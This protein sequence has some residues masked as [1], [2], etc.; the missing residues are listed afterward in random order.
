MAVGKFNK[1]FICLGHGFYFRET[2]DLDLEQDFL[3]KLNSMNCDAG[4]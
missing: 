1:D 2:S 3:S 4:C